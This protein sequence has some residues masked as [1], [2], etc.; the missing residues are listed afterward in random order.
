[1]LGFVWLTDRHGPRGGPRRDESR[2]DPPYGTVPRPPHPD[3][4][5]AHG[6]DIRWR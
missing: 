5:C 2:L 4:K 1:M 3:L 6:A